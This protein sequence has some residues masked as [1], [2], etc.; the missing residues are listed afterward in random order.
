MPR[1]PGVNHLHAVRALQKAG[2]HIAHQGKHIKMAK[3][4]ITVSIPRH[5]PINPSTMGNIVVQTGL[6]VA[7]FRNLL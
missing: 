7:E 6:T 5:N 1:V 3:G 4:Q 2:F